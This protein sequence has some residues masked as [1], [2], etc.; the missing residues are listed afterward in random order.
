MR[1]LVGWD[2]Y[3]SV[4]ALEALNALYA[5]LRLFQN[6]FQPSMKLVRKVRI[7]S[8]LRRQYDRPQTPFERVQ[9]CGQADPT[10]LAAL[11]RVRRTTDPFALSRRIDQQ[12][13]RLWALA[14]RVTRTPREQVPRSPHAR[15]PWRGWT[16]SPRLHEQK[17]QIAGSTRVSGK[18]AN[19]VSSPAAKSPAVRTRRG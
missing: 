19:G 4:A 11:Q 10:R 5:D 18:G 9:A 13:E 12:L 1:K 14:N 8:R 6:L 3:D 2:R 16:F 17:R 7:G 15:T